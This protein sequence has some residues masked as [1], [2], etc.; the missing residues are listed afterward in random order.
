MTGENNEETMND[1]DNLGYSI[2]D[3][4]FSES[5]EI[6]K[7]LEADVVAWNDQ[8]V[9]SASTPTKRKN[10]DV[11]QYGSVSADLKKARPFD[12]SEYFIAIVL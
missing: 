10:D 8:H 11:R 1:S 12:T 3:D 2:I 7:E 4:I 9:N 5:V 6:P